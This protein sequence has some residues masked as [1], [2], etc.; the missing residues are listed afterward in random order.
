M[1]ESAAERVQMVNKRAA[2]WPAMRSEIEPPKLHHGDSKFLLVG[3]GSTQGA[4]YEAVE[5]L[6]GKGFDV[7]CAC[8]CD[9]WPF[10]AKR[11]EVILNQTEQFFMVE[12]N[13]TAQLGQ[14]IRSQT[15]LKEAGAVLKYDGRPFFPIE[16]RDGFLQKTG[17]GH[18]RP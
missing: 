16:I 2:K 1:T 9:L 15:G 17:Y 6:R 7:G 10:P 14:I 12:Q 13:S 11:V 3:W 5:L 4:L 8:F 18:D